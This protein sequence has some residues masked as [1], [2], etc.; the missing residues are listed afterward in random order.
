MKIKTKD[1]CSAQNVVNPILLYY[2]YV[3]AFNPMV[4]DQI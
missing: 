3:F 2:I 4:F 1:M